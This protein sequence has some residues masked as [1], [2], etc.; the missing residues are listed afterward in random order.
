MSALLLGFFACCG[1]FLEKNSGSEG[2]RGGL[3]RCSFERMMNY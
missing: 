2:G 1:G 3:G